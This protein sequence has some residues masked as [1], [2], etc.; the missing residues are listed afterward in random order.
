VW[1]S[2]GPHARAG[3]LSHTRVASRLARIPE[4]PLTQPP[5]PGLVRA[6]RRWDLTALAIN[7]IIGAGIFGLPSEV[8]RRIGA[9]SL[10]AFVVCALVVTL[11]ILCFAEVGSRFSETGG[12]YLYAREAFGP[13][14]GFEVGWLIWVARLTAFAANSNLLVDYLGFFWP[15]AT[16]GAG[17]VL[18][19][20]L[21]I[22]G[23]TAINLTGVRNAANVGNFFTI[24][25]LIPLLLF[26]GA[27]VFFL[28]PGRYSLAARPPFGEFS[29]SVLLLIYAFSGFEMAAIP[30]GEVRDPRRDIPRALLIAIAV[31]AVVY[32]MIQLVAI[33]TLPELASSSRPLAEAGSRFLGRAGGAVI[34]LGALV[35]IA[36]NL[37]VI[38]LVAAR[39][40]YAMAER[41][42]LPA[43]LAAT[44]HRFR[45]P[46]VSVLVTSAVAL[47]LAL[48]GSFVYAATISVIAR[49]LSYSM[50]AAAL[51][52]LRYRKGIPPAQFPVRGGVVVAVLT[53][54]LSAWLLSHTSGRQARD[55][56]IA[57]GFGL[58][59]YLLPKLTRRNS[60][61]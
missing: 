29:V 23:F 46:Y 59:L 5:R 58:L 17:R 37:F 55:A 54:I 13:V 56:A 61:A 41:H 14:V 9:Y 35:S 15:G 11:I 24:A 31:V 21:V 32:F 19:I 26:I 2:P 40:P 16:A 45:T 22:A 49:L 18:V 20:T 4:E 43:F 28:D 36:G 7:S 53:L 10:I 6:I 1:A 8:Y 34:S 60:P 47:V 30:G 50:T 27:G 48:T 52:V 3:R 25:K 39:L 42:E 12:P 57:A 44:H 38:L 33:G 51:P